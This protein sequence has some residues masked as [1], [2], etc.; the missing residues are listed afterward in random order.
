MK[1]DNIPTRQSNK[2]FALRVFF[3]SLLSLPCCH[4]N[5]TPDDT[6]IESETDSSTGSTAQTGD[7]GGSIEPTADTGTSTEETGDGC[8]YALNLG[9]M[10]GETYCEGLTLDSSVATDSI[11]QIDGVPNT[12][13]YI[14]SN[15]HRR[16]IPSDTVLESWWGVDAC[17]VCEQVTLLNAAD[18]ATIPINNN[19]TARP[20]SFIIRIATDP[21]LFVVDDCATARATDEVTLEA[22]YGPNWLTL[23]RTFPEFIFI[24]YDIGSP[25]TSVADYDL[26]AAQNRTLADELA[27]P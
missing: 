26:V 14:D 20:G 9:D 7:T 19:I 12:I 1:G 10:P 3:L 6:D 24:D 21:T 4:N 23:V 11:M 17:I 13:Y 5:Q 16:T 27:C 2:E 8:S 25:V 18:A 22:I 15:R